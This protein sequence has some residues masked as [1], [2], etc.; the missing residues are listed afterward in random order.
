MLQLQSY[1]LNSQVWSS[2]YT[3]QHFLHGQPCYM[4][5]RPLLLY[6]CLRLDVVRDSLYDHADI[7]VGAQA[8][9]GLLLNVSTAG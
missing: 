1:K 5:L 9:T 4:L 6:C 7:C 3:F 8:S 2:S